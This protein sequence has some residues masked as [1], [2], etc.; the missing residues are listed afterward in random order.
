VS[1]IKFGLKSWA[2]ASLAENKREAADVDDLKEAIA[3]LRRAG[4][5]KDLVAEVEKVVAGLAKRNAEARK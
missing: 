5:S 3:K 1:F 2:K 4:V